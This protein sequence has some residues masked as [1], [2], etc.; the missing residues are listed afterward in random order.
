MNQKAS[1]LLL[2]CSPNLVN[3]YRLATIF[4]ITSHKNPPSEL[5]ATFQKKC[6][7]NLMNKKSP[8]LKREELFYFRYIMICLNAEAMVFLL[9]SVH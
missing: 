6:S 1:K 8:F 4:R 2:F 9:V 5:P 3:S 7:N